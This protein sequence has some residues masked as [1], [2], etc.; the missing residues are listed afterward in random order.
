MTEALNHSRN[1]TDDNG[2][3]YPYKNDGRVLN[4]AIGP[5]LVAS[6]GAP[7]GYLGDPAVDTAVTG[8]PTGNNVFRIEGPDNAFSN[9]A[10]TLPDV[11]ETDLF[12]VSGKLYMGTAFEVTN[13]GADLR[14]AGGTVVASYAGNGPGT[15]V[16]IDD[17]TLAAATVNATVVQNGGLLSPGDSAG[18]TVI[19]GNYT[20]GLGGSILIE[21]AGP[22]GPG[23]WTVTTGSTSTAPPRSKAAWQSTSWRNWTSAPCS[24]SLATITLSANSPACPTAPS[25]PCRR[26]SASRTCSTSITAPARSTASV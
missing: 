20:L 11:V 1:Y 12:A 18:T 13:N 17:G 6:T 5:F 16:T 4:S 8:S 15:T 26:T 2:D 9:D 22:E 24:P 19:N 7:A 23:P 25:S 3:L 21:I 14:L 10:D